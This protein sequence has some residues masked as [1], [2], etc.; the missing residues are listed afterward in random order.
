MPKTTGILKYQKILLGTFSITLNKRAS[1]NA[2]IKVVM[3]QANAIGRSKIGEKAQS[4]IIAQ[5]GQKIS[6]Y[7]HSVSSQQNFRTVLT[8]YINYVKNN[9]D[10]KVLKSV[11]SNT[12]SE[13]IYQKSLEIKGSSL[14]SYIST[15][16]KVS[17]TFNSFGI[18]TT[19][20]AS[21]T[22]L[23]QD[24]KAM[25]VSLQK[26][27]I[28]R[29]YSNP[30]ALVEHISQHTLYGLSAKLQLYAGL[31]ID[32]ATNFNKLHIN[33]NNTL[34]V[35]RSKGGIN[36]A[37]KKLSQRLIEELQEAKKQNVNIDKGEY[38]NAL[39]NASK[40]TS[41][42]YQGSHGLRYNYANFRVKELI[43]SDSGLSLKE[44]QLQCSLEMGHSRVEIVEHYLFL[45]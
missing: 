16:A 41:Q 36:Y 44:S 43:D 21:I 45:V 42:D 37:T 14:N 25:G 30:I 11:N 34:R 26:E 9:Y 29:S 33:D 8:Q 5:N 1:A 31:R 19:D 18:D 15:M 24:I 27:N 39:I 20:R 3:N 7:N 12:M 40:E 23:R 22:S 4:S 17:D 6:Q 13:F 38:R 10:G 28:N 2:I 35:I 32:D